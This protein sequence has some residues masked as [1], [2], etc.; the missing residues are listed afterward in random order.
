[1]VIDDGDLAGLIACASAGEEA[2]GGKRGAVWAAPGVGVDAVARERAVRRHAETY[3]LDLLSPVDALTRPGDPDARVSE[4]RLL[5]DAGE[6]AIKAGLGRIVWYVH[7]GTPAGPGDGLDRVALTCDRALLASRLLT[8]DA[9]AGPE[10][11]I[12]AA[13]VDFSDVQMAELAVD[14]DVALDSCWWAMA[15]GANATLLAEARAARDRWTKAMESAGLGDLL[16][17]AGA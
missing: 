10:V 6:A 17:R 7:H 13:Y 4:T 12:E 11:R 9:G 15:E 1:M 8:L 3:G 14:L 5:I 16:M 2:A